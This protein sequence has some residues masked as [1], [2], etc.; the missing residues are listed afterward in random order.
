MKL[1]KACIAMAAF[2]AIFVVP[3]MASATS[4]TLCETTGE[5]LTC[6]PVAA[7]TLV[8]GTN[9]VHGSHVV[10]VLDAGLAGKVQCTGATL[11]GEVETNSNA[12]IAGNI[13]TAEFGGTPGGTTTGHCS[14]NS[15]L[16]EKITPTPTHTSNPCHTPT[17]GTAHCSLPWC[18]TANELNDTFTVRGGKCS[19][20]TRPL[21]FTLHGN[22]ECKY[23]K[24]SVTGTYTTHPET[25][26]VL[27]ITNQEFK[28]NTTSSGFC[29]ATGKLSMSFT[30]STDTEK[31]EP[32]YIT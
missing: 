20:A 9:T 1:V 5:P 16:G 28:R 22:I 6:H 15:V 21:T 17:G 31:E 2:A 27:T 29:P 10:S 24:A 12:H 13:T 7:G 30:L 8:T 32:L 11:T 14:G 25:D 19:E 26:A 3:S 23:E 4:P 18:V